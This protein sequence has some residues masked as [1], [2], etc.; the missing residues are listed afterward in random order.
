M[1]DYIRTMFAF[2]FACSVGN[3]S[4][5]GLESAYTLSLPTGEGRSPVKGSLLFV[6]GSGRKSGSAATFDTIVS[7]TMHPHLMPAHCSVLPPNYRKYR[8]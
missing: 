7:F 1:S 8:T 3:T 4:R 5:K 2:L 6:V